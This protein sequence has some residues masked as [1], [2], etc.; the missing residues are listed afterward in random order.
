ML[1]V[2]NP[3]AA[4]GSVGRHWPDVESRMRSAIGDMEVEY[5]SEPWSAVSLVRSA[6]RRGESDI[7]I[8]GGDGSVNEVLNGFIE[9]DRLVDRDAR[10]TIIPVGSGCDY[11]KTLGLPSGLEHAQRLLRSE[12][13]RTVDVGKATYRS[14][15]GT[16]ETRY[17]ANILE[18]G[19]GGAVVDKVNRSSKPFGGRF[20]FMWAIITTLPSYTNEVVE[21]RVDGELVAEGPMNSVIVANGMY[22]GSGLKPAPKAELDDGIFDLVLFGDIHF[23]DALRNLG[24]LRKGEHV[25]HPKVKY[26]RGKSVSATA[27]AEVLAEM[28]GELIGTLPMD[29]TILPH[30]LQVR[31]LGD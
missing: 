31:V 12:V 16:T 6:L 30:L 26:L 1:F 4:G 27:Q 13:F 24:K 18:A 11:A 21:V 17:F 19:A 25:E 23:G 20:A 28:D 14:L 5:T 3:T 9:D 29:V 7:T 8:V 2:V 15:Q 22:Y 10:L